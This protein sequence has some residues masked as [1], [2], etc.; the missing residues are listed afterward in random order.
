M[1]E[2]QTLCSFIQSSDAFS[3]EFLPSGDVPNTWPPMLNETEKV[4]QALTEARGVVTEYENKT[5]IFP[6][7]VEK[8]NSMGKRNGRSSW[9]GGRL[10]I[11][12][13]VTEVLYKQLKEE[14][15]GRKK[16]V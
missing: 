16:S 1:A 10:H 7:A 5:N 6:G 12:W 11:C 13:V 4:A 9:G 3:I 14:Y 8:E 2:S 15:S